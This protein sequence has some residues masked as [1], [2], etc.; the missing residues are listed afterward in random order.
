MPLPIYCS[1]LITLYGAVDAST[2]VYSY[3]EDKISVIVT[4]IDGET[5]SGLWLGVTDGT[6]SLGAQGS[7]PKKIGWAD[8]ERIAFDVT[9]SGHTHGDQLLFHLAGG[10][11]TWGVIAEGNEEGVTVNNVLPDPVTLSYEDL[12]AIEL[13]SGNPYEQAGRIFHDALGSRLAGQDVLIT[14]G[15]DDVQTLRGTIERMDAHGGRFKFADRSRT[16]GND[17][18]YG[19]VFAAGVGGQAHY[20][21]AVELQDGSI[22]SGSS[23]VADQAEM[24]LVDSVARQPIPMALVRTIS[25]KSDRVTYLSDM[26]PASQRSEGRLH[27]SWP[28]RRDKSVSNEPITLGGR[29][30]EKGL[31]V[32]SFSE[33][34]FDLAGEYERFVATIG[35]DDS[36]RPRGSV[37]FRVALD[38]NILFD[39]G[40]ASGRDEPRQVS[41]NVSGGRKLT[42]TVDYG[43]GL[44]LSD[45]ADWAGARLIKV[46]TDPTS[47]STE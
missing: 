1:L 39:S 42:L 8:I 41:L 2:S 34:S 44:D 29:R 9:Q 37:I 38:G 13:V 28:M 23:L 24:T 20:A 4:L 3:W 21:F 17:K 16:F 12:A 31:G 43:D 26:A 27:R 10:G 15:P 5:T 47:V 33:L 7:E 22:F 30:Y 14:R 6:F 46:N 19:I 32:H 25:I 35:I 40:A 18:M 36:M 45:Q 11:R